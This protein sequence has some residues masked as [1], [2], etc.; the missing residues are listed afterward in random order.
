MKA[1]VFALCATIFMPLAWCVAAEQRQVE[2]WGV[3]EVAL[4]GP[5]A[6]N[7][8]VDVDLS[9]QFTIGQ[10]T[11][12][13]NGFYDGE[14]RYVLRF[15][16]EALGMYRYTTKSGVRELDGQQGAF[17]CVNP[18]TGNHGPVRVK[19]TYHFAY[20]DGTPYYPFGTTCYAWIHQ[21]DELQQQTLKTLA[22]A[23][24]NKIRMC[25]FPKNYA[26]NKNEPSIYPFAKDSAAKFDFTRFNPAFFRHLEKR[27][28]ELGSLG[29]DADL[30]LFHPYDEGRWGFDRMDAQTDRR[31]VRYVVA[32][33]SAFR[34]VWWSMA[35]EYDFMRRKQASDWDDFFQLVQQ[36]D[37]YNHFRGVHN[38]TRWYDH[39]KPW[40]THAS[41]QSAN[42]QDAK[43]W[44]RRYK[45]PI[46]DDECQYEGNIA[47]PWGNISAQELVHRFWLGTVVG[48][49]VGH[50][51]TYVDANDVLWWSK[52]GVLRGQSPSRIA[53]LRKL[54]EEGP[55]VG[56]EPLEG[57][58]EWDVY[59]GGR[60]GDDYYLVYFG[61]H[62]P[63]SV[64]LPL[65]QAEYKAEVID[66]WNMTIA[67]VEGAFR[68][69]AS[70]PLPGK[71]YVALRLQKRQ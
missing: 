12:R 70:I 28:T 52:G 61:S 50:G 30:I 41:I 25:V 11:L 37:P 63:I 57:S 38:G 56:L 64:R 60:K 40:V 16:P 10:S 58:W 53:F 69:K 32:R 65:P 55:P 42:L 29:I 6:G 33:L 23:P 17:E 46:V 14:G 13:V 1:S 15:M 44:R 24:F 49:Y 21:T 5:A 51:E 45:K 8:F 27:V 71:P 39:N 59:A 18:S 68:G 31:Y 26:Y 62:Q 4:K 2:R 47:E 9:A 36:S 7:P 22:E 66:T 43:Q 3:F 34:N 20:A 54:V 48:C 35:N 19:D 67:P